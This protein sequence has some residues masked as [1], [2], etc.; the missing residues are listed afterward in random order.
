MPGGN[1]TGPMGMGS[2]TGRAAGYCA[3]YPIPGHTNPI[4]GRG[5]GS[6]G[7]RGWGRGFRSGWGRRALP[8]GAVP[9]SAPPYAVPYYGAAP[10]RE[11]ELELLQ[12][13]AEGLKGALEDIQQR[14]S[15]LEG[16]ENK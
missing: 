13:Q 3:G 2:M 14:M 4:S 12:S 6:G 9:A 5:F 10:T 8:Y 7:G 1:G 11:Q 15:K 16:E